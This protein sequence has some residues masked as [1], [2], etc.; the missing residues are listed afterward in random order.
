MKSTINSLPKKSGAAL[1]VREDVPI[2]LSR[3][4]ASLLIEDRTALVESDPDAVW[5]WLMNGGH[6]FDRPQRGEG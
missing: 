5:R 3:S 1:S 6:G 4:D 2:G